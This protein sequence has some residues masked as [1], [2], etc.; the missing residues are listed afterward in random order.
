[1]PSELTAIN[2]KIDLLSRQVASQQEALGDSPNGTEMAALHAKLDLIMEQ[3]AEQ[4][5]RQQELN[6]LKN[7]LL[8][9]ANHMIKL[10]IEELAKITTENFQSL[11]M[12]EINN[13]GC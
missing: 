6:E 5:R 4:R 9:I 2:E 1:M 8:P 3:L 10:S 11:F 12:I 7:D 13:L